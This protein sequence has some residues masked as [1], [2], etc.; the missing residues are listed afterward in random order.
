MV[1]LDDII[2][3]GMEAIALKGWSQFTLRGLARQE[4]IDFYDLINIM[5]T[6]EDFLT[7]A[8]IWVDSQYALS[9]S[10]LGA[11]QPLT[12]AE[13]LFES[14]MGR[15]D[16]LAAYR[17][18]F[19]NIKET[20]AT[21]PLQAFHIVQRWIQHLYKTFGNHNTSSSLYTLA[22]V[23]LYVRTFWVWIDDDESFSST[24]KTLDESIQQLFAWQGI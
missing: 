7:T 12:K 10:S 1:M 18:A 15:L 8:M 5:P 4:G 2:P 22:Q 11:D 16:L 13:Q 20:L 24:M 6:K 14:I 21:E 17:P 23:G 19:K 9:V 3:K